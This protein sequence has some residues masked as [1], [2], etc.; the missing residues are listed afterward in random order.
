MG[1]IDWTPTAES[2]DI[3][4]F[5][6]KLIAL[7]QK[8][9]ALR[10]PQFADPFDEIIDLTLKWHGTILNQPDWRDCSHTLAFELISTNPKDIRFYAAFNA[11]KE[12]L[13]FELPKRTWLSLINTALDS[14]NDCNAIETASICYAR[15]ITVQPDSVRVLASVNA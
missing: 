3:L 9:P 12:P 6:Q 1:W 4:C 14:P 11:W 2:N 10:V 5:V 13:D 8:Y 7:R 15:K